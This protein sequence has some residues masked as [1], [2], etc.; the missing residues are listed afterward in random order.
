MQGRSRVA[1]G[2]RGK[3]E[4]AL[5]AMEVEKRRKEFHSVGNGPIEGVDKLIDWG[6]VCFRFT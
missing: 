6:L 3:T 1:R 5:V 2:R 4:E